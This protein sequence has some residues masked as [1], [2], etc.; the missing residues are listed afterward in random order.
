[1]CSPVGRLQTRRL[2][3]CKT[4]TKNETFS[5][6]RVGSGESLEVE[7]RFPKVYGGVPGH[8]RWAAVSP[9]GGL[10]LAQWSGE[11]EVPTAFFIE[12]VG[13]V[14][15]SVTGPYSR[16]KP[17]V[18]SE[19][20]GWTTDERAIVFSPELPGCGSTVDSGVFLINPS[21]P[22]ERIAR[23]EPREPSPIRASRTPRSEPALRRALE[24]S[25]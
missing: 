9:D 6:F 2:K 22:V 8:W 5:E 16:M 3:L 25:L 24:S 13:G 19:A 20:L 17:P 10:I 11:C 23:A 1:M 21:G 15:R 18:S 4:F 12:A 7:L 14:P